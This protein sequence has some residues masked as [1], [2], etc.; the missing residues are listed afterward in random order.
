VNTEGHSYTYK[1][2]LDCEIM[3]IMSNPTLIS[4]CNQFSSLYQ[5]KF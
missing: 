4:V 3:F 1:V 2:K 5:I